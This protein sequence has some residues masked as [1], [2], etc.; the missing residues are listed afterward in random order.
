MK[1]LTECPHC[2][3]VWTFDEIQYQRCFDCG[4]P[5]VDDD[6][7]EEDFSLLTDPEDF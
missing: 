2:P 7:E 4:W 3:A 5:D 1:A 6:D